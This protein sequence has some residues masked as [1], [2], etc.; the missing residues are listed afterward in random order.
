MNSF[1][2]QLILSNNAFNQ[3]V[4]SAKKCRARIQFIQSQNEFAVVDHH[5]R[6]LA[7][8]ES[9]IARYHAEQA[10]IGPTIKGQKDYSSFFN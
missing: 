2:N 8:Q 4:A 1:E 5:E 3:A 7:T 6:L 10:E 9:I